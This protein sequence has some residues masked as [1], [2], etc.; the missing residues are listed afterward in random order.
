M[1][2]IPLAR[3]SLLASTAS[4]AIPLA[5]TAPALGQTA[6]APQAHAPTVQDPGVRGGARGA[7]GPLPGLNTEETAFFKATKEIFEEVNTVPDGLGPRFNLDGCAG[8]HV[9]PAVGGTSPAVNPQVAVATRL[10]ANN[11]VPPFVTVDGPVREARF[12]KK[13][14]GT[15]DGGVH[16]LFVISGR[17]D[18]PSACRIVQDNFAAAVAANNVIFRIP[19]P[20]FGLGLVETVRDSALRASLSAGAGRKSSLGISGRFNVNENDGTITRF[21]WKAQ[22]KSLLI[23]SA[24]A[25][26][27]EQGVTNEGFPTEREEDP[28]CAVTATPE[29]PTR[30]VE[31]ED[32]GSPAA[33][34]SADIVS[35]AGFMRFLAPPTP[36][37]SPATAA[38][39][40]EVMN[41]S[42]TAAPPS[43]SSPARGKMVFDNIGCDACHTPSLKT[44]KST[45]NSLSNKTFSPLSDFALHD[46]GVGLEDRVSQG[47]AS[48]REFRTAP[49][50]GL[51][52]RIFFLHDGRTTD[53]L[54]AIRQHSSTGSEAKQVIDNFEM[55]GN[56]DKQ[57]LLNYLRSL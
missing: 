9:Q 19:T 3:L 18:A 8:C 38:S 36:A 7:G 31:E 13:P 11:V 5:M 57:A 29:D 32:L 12:V 56:G 45:F 26:N 23:F 24:E 39:A 33:N 6:A 34:F 22:N 30:L 14:D 35:F 10:G 1:T 46:M 44:G 27:V 49:L 17:S 4:I 55:L 47:G 43:S 37:T 28:K 21:G 42:L 52:Q 48:G 40:A 50:W 25:Y 15:P 53:L 51:G 16:G 41:A 20:L 2:R 54:V